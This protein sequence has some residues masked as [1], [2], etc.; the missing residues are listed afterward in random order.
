VRLG[1]LDIG[2]TSAHLRVVDA[3]PGSPPL[4]VGWHKAPTRLAEAIRTDGVVTA[5][6]VGRLVAAVRSAVEM[7]RVQQVTDLIPFA[8][9]AVRDATNRDE[10][11]A[12]LRAEAGLDVGFFS[13]E[14]EARLTYFAVHRW[15]GWSA[16]RLLLLDIGGG[17]MEIAEGRDEDPDVAVSL[18]L[19]AGRLTRSHLPDHPAGRRQVK[20]LRAHVREVI[21]PAVQRLQW[22]GP[23]RTV[24]AASKTFKQLARLAGEVDPARPAGTRTL[25]RRHLRAW[26]PRLAAMTPAERADLR[27]VKP[28][29][30]KQM[31]AGAVVAATVMAALRLDQVEI[32]P[33]ALREGILLRRLASTPDVDALPQVRLL[34]TFG[35]DVAD[36]AER[37]RARRRG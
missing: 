15:Y 31:L 27:G 6:G 5:A 23:P 16:G 33:W 25:Y 21:A 13:G 29:R 36:L 9:S 34:D 24:V 32:C 8:T 20:R 4:S 18:P 2:S 28:A 35:A 19:G 11:V 12:A 3:Y 7:A 22:D 17:S 30:A 14:D 37:R 1:V 10:I 26:I